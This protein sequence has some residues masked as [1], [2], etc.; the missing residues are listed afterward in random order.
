MGR[1]GVLAADGLPEQAEEVAWLWREY[2]QMRGEGRVR[3]LI[4]ADFSRSV[5]TIFLRDANF[6]D[7][8]VLMED[9]R[10]YEREH[11][12]PHGIKLTLAGDV[13][14]SQTLISAIVGTQVVSVGAALAGDLIVLPAMLVGP[15]GKVFE[16]A[17]AQPLPVV[18]PSAAVSRSIR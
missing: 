3:Q 9:L 7:T 8:A 6:R 14:V 15:L 2:A 5:I 11:L 18:E 12:A 4:S 1:S 13:A 17:A 16:P 10:A